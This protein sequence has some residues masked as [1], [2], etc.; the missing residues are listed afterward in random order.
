[1]EIIIKECANNPSMPVMATNG[2]LYDMVADTG[3]D[4]HPGETKLFKSGFKMQVPEGYSLEVL[5]RSGMA[6]KNAVWVANA[7][8]IVDS[9]YRG[10]VGIILY[11]GGHGTYRVL[12]GDRIAQ[13][14]LVKNVKFEFTHGPLSETE[15]GE[16]GFGSTGK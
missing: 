10:E 4:I 15:R 13:C 8:G 2:S 11:N 14:R 6:L 16:G 9:D 12:R 1:M 7:P 3:G 5:S